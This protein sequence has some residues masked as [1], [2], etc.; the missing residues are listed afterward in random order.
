MRELTVDG[1]DVMERTGGENVKK[2]VV[3]ER[4]IAMAGTEKGVEGEL[5]GYA[6]ILDDI[7]SILE[8]AKYQAYKAVDNIRVQTLLAGW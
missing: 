1:E 6:E 8:K 2:E 5:V 7:K 4:E 3:T